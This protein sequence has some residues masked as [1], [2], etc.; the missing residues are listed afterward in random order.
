M[1]AVHQSDACSEHPAQGEFQQVTAA[2]AYRYALLNIGALHI[3]RQVQGVDLVFAAVIGTAPRHQQ[4]AVAVGLAHQLVFVAHR[5]P[6][7]ALGAHYHKGVID[8]V[9]G[10]GFAAHPHQ[11]AAGIGPA[12]H[13]L[14]AAVHAGLQLHR[15]Q[16]PGQVGLSIAGGIALGIAEVV[17]HPAFAGHRAAVVDALATGAVLAALGAQGQ[18]AVEVERDDQLRLHGPVAVTDFAVG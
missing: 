15:L 18:A 8:A 6:G 12:R 3:R 4:M 9:G 16:A 17:A 1:L 2:T 5:N 7:K 11:R 13:G 10:K 14:T